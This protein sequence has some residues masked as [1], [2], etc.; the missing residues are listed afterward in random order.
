MVILDMIMDPG[1]DGLETYERILKH[2][3]GQK[4]LI[5]SG[6][7]TSDRIH[8]ALALGAGGYLRKPYHLKELG[9][10]VKEALNRDMTALSA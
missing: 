4:A 8:K 5:V 9:H 2:H 7:S 6:Y 10:A 1:I 3:P